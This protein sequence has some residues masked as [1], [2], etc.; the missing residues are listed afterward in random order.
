MSEIETQSLIEDLAFQWQCPPNLAA[1][2]IVVAPSEDTNIDNCLRSIRNSTGT[3]IFLWN[4]GGGGLTEKAAKKWNVEHYESHKENT[5]FIGPNNHL[6]KLGDSEYVVLINSDAFVNKGWKELLIGRLLHG[7][8]VVGFQGSKL[9][10]DG[11]GYG[12]FS[13]YDIDFVSGWGLATRRKTIDRLGLFDPAYELALCED[14]DF[15]LRVKSAG[16]GVYGLHAK[17]AIHIG[18]CGYR[19]IKDRTELDR[20]AKKNLTTL[21]RRWAGHVGRG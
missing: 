1:D 6:A 12:W 11:R 18:G 3:R 10:L 20:A 17:A 14:S 13:G 4:N 16:L 2:I 19:A 7:D 5:G 9:N 15:C 21:C 8:A